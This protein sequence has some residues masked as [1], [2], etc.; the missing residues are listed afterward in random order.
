M[1]M[2][3]PIA[4]KPA[5]TAA[6]S[7]LG[8]KPTSADDLA[9]AF[10]ANA[11][12]LLSFAG[13]PSQASTCSKHGLFECLWSMTIKSLLLRTGMSV[14]YVQQDRIQGYFTWLRL[15]HDLPHS[16]LTGLLMPCLL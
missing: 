2:M 15:L 10:T 9:G 8:V 12:V 1:R 11:D 4:N 14:W 3:S 6:M 13:G 7:Q 5:A 16:D